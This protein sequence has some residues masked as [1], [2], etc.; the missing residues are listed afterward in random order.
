MQASITLIIIAAIAICTIIG[1]VSY[2]I[3]T[4]YTPSV[5]TYIPEANKM[6][7]TNSLTGID[8]SIVDFSSKECTILFWIYINK[9]PETFASYSLLQIGRETYA[10]DTNAAAPMNNLC[11]IVSNGG[12][13]FSIPCSN[14]ASNC[15]TSHMAKINVPYMPTERWVQVAA[16]VSLI[17]NTLQLYVDGESVSPNSVSIASTKDVTINAAFPQSG[18]III[19]SASG[20]SGLLS[21]IAFS[22]TVLTQDNIQS[23]YNKGPT[24]K[25]QSVSSLPVYGW[26]TLFKSPSDKVATN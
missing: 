26:R 18:H 25:M 10:A 15:D 2:L 17:N 16:T 1:I 9:P 24:G 6:I 4:Y 21:N 8:N 14:T 3:F 7:S 12:L 23:E 13:T 22:K 20:F 11:F 5:I 19:S